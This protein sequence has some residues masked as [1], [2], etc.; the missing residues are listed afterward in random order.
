MLQLYNSEKCTGWLTDW[1]KESNPKWHWETAKKKF[2]EEREPKQRHNQLKV[3][4]QHC[5][6]GE[7][8][9][10]QTNIDLDSRM[11]NI[12]QSRKLQQQQNQNSSG[13][14]RMP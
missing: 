3:I 2:T 10:I 4:K 12:P 1:E 13:S 14:K 8:T 6:Q 11:K 7:Q 5:K 9:E